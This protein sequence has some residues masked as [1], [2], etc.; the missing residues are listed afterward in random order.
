MIVTISILFVKYFICDKK[1]EKNGILAD[2]Y[3]KSIRFYG[4]DWT[5]YLGELILDNMNKKEINIISPASNQGI[6]EKQIFKYIA[7]SGKKINF[8]CSDICKIEEYEK[9]EDIKNG[10]YRYIPLR[11]AY[12]IKNTLKDV[13]IEKVDVILDLKGAL[14]YTLS[15]R[16][17]RF[18]K[19]YNLLDKYNEVLNDKGIIIIDNYKYSSLLSFLK[20]IA[21]VFNKKIFSEEV[22]TYTLIKRKS[23]FNKKIMRKIKNKFEI[24]ECNKCSGK[25]SFVVLKKK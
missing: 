11:N 21:K 6:I 4:L 16:F 13:S 1:Y 7:E 22:P 18:G 23:F 24:I 10:K 12:N 2:W 20:E 14:W 17:F 5:K 15:L 8:I 25:V 9:D 3:D 19:F